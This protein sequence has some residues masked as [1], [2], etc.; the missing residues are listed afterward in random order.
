MIK[1]AFILAAGLGT[2][3]KELTHAIPKPMIEVAGQSLITRLIDQLIAYGITQIV[4]NIFY[5]ADLL[6]EHVKEHMRL[7]APAIKVFF[8]QE[9]ELLDTGGGI[10]NALKYLE[11]KPFFVINNDSI[12]VGKE[13]VFAFLNNNWK[14]SMNMLFLLTPAEKAMGYDGKGDFLLGDKNQL[15]R[16]DHTSRT[17]LHEGH[18]VY[19]YT[20]IHITTPEIFRGHTPGKIKLM[21]IY[22]NA[23]KKEQEIQTLNQGSAPHPPQSRH[24]LPSGEKKEGVDSF[25]SPQ[26]VEGKDGGGYSPFP[27]PLRGEGAAIAADEGGGSQ[28]ETSFLGHGIIYPGQWLHV[29]TP[30]ALKQAKLYLKK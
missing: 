16:I 8:S 12:F 30:G 14:S 1:R 17:K 15:I 11:D 26:I 25:P 18:R 19:V 28:F 21:D 3:M 10:I 22:D 6:M 13:N 5:K 24:L 23:L 29:G 4:I 7:H 27:S 20:G 9:S 2:R